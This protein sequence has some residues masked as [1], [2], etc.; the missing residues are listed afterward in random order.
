M[1]LHHLDGHRVPVRVRCQPVRD[2][3]G[4]VVGAVE[5][6][7]ED[8]V[9]L[10]ALHRIDDLEQLATTDN[11]TGIPN[12]R[13]A[14]I[15]LRSRTRDVTE[16][17]WPLAVLFVDI[18]R[19]KDFNDR[20][21]HA[22][23]DR[24]LRVVARSV[25]GA[26]READVVARWGGDEFVILSA[27]STEAQVEAVAERVRSLVAASDVAVGGERLAVTVSVGAVLAGRSETVEDVLGRADEALYRSKAGG[28]DRVVFVRRPGVAA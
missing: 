1:F 14:E 4:E 10:D 12:R 2:Q 5:I 7:S 17:G 24:V 13:A 26:L 25:S 19:F 15:S 28:R 27:S 9:Y 11:L 16:A 21:G 3:G 20:Y 8:T 22:V 18:D 6:F 23:G